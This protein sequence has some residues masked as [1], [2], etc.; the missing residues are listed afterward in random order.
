MNHLQVQNHP[1]LFNIAQAVPNVYPNGNVN[2]SSNITLSPPPYANEGF[3]K[4]AFGLIDFQK[5]LE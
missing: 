5:K 4:T 1:H 2:F 3:E